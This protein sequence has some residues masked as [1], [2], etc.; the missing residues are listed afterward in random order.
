VNNV[1]Y[2]VMLTFLEFYEVLVGFVNFKLFHS[3]G[4]K[5]PPQLDLQKD[6]LGETFRSIIPEAIT[7][8]TTATPTNKG[9]NAKLAEQLKKKSEQRLASLNDALS[10]IAAHKAEPDTAN[11]SA[12][13]NPEDTDVF[14]EE[15]EKLKLEA[16]IYSK[17]FD[18]CVVFL[19][20]EVCVCPA[21]VL[22]SSCGTDRLL[23]TLTSFKG[24]ER[25]S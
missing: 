23:F 12:Q 13:V 24:S 21:R 9:G 5:Y 19:S 17:L 8:T 14:D 1:D 6:E 22:P 25:A 7:P 20:R 18:G 15:T 3:L 16:E 10:K 11:T 4:M 2:K